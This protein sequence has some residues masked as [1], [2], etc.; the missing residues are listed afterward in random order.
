MDSIQ[1][2]VKRRIAS[3]GRGNVFTPKDFLDVG[4]RDA[5]DQ[6]LGRLVRSDFIHRVGRGLSHFPR[7]NPRIGIDVPAAVDDLAHALGRQTGST[8]APSG[9][10]AANRL[11]LSTQVPAVPVYLSNGR[12]RTAVVGNTTIQIK[13][14]A[15]K[16][17]PPGRR[18]SALVFQALTYL[19]REA[20]D[21][22]VIRTIR[23][24]LTPS[25]RR[26]LLR[27]A[28]YA[29]DWIAEV[30]RRI[31]GDSAEGSAG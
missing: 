9:A 20:V 6:A 16:L 17:W 29:T 30:A 5:I 24:R 1:S 15:P 19:G 7:H 11:G 13:H 28:R 10:V 18:M 23:K 21:D 25:Q 2:Q 8:V 31:A 26:Q 14:V 22:T 27:D 4:G 3:K 12:S